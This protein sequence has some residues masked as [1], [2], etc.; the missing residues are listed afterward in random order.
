MTMTD[1]ELLANSLKNK[2][3]SIELISDYDFVLPMIT[4]L[5]FYSNFTTQRDKPAN[6]SSKL[7]AYEYSH[8]TSFN[9]LLDHLK[10]FHMGYDQALVQLNNSVVPH[11]SELDFV[12]GLPLL[13]MSGLIKSK[14]RPKYLYNYT[15]EEVEFSLLVIDYWTNF[16][17]Y[18]YNWGFWVRVSVL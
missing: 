3:Q 16:A 17:K 9:Y 6:K 11:F 12:F 5:K 4:Q 13:S 1:Q 18:G 10:S 14:S 7:F 15:K 8:I 2:I